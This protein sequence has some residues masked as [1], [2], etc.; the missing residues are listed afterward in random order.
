MNYFDNLTAISNNQNIILND[1]KTNYIKTIQYH[2]TKEINDLCWSISPDNIIA[3][4]SDDK[5][6]Y[7]S[8][9]I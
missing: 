3:T 7:I 4:V 5:I 9:V 2:H 1:N 6:C 8:R